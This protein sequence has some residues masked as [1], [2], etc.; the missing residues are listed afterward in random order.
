MIQPKR[1]F[2]PLYK[3]FLRLKYFENNRKIYQFKRLKWENTSRQIYRRKSFFN[4]YLF[5]RFRFS[6]YFKVRF[7]HNLLKKQKLKLFLGNI[8]KYKLKKIV[9]K[10]LF[11]FYKNKNKLLEKNTFIGKYLIHSIENQL[12]MVIKRALFFLSLRKSKQLISQGFVYVNNKQIK[13]Y[14][15]ELKTNDF[16]CFKEKIY[17]QLDYYFDYFKQFNLRLFKNFPPTYLKI[18]YKTLSIVIVKDIKFSKHENLYP[19]LIE[20]NNLIKLKKL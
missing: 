17:K 4:H 5:S 12:Y 1:R 14:S 13:S 7:R 2:K 10:S 16:I 9:K 18:N 3:K 20:I 19:F 6:I 15:Y 8:K 11:L